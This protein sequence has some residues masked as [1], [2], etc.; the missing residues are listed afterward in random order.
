MQTASVLSP[1]LIIL[2]FTPLWQQRLRTLIL[3]PGNH[4][5]CGGG[6][7]ESL[8]GT[9]WYLST[10]LGEDELL[11]KQPTTIPMYRQPDGHGS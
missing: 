6:P 5:C 1:C 8:G 3:N 11:D 4:A 7:A 2:F 10:A 9:T